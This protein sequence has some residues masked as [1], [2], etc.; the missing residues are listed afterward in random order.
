MTLQSTPWSSRK[1]ERKNTSD[2]KGMEQV[3]LK[4]ICRV[5]V[6]A[7]KPYER[8]KICIECHRKA[9]ITCV[10][11]TDDVLICKHFF[12]LLNYSDSEED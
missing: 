5:C 7:V 1:R 4:N 10:Q 6:V 12:S 8:C 2:R 11:T 3:D 9:H